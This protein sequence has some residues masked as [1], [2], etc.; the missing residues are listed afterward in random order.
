[1]SLKRY[2]YT[3]IQ[4]FELNVFSLIFRVDRLMQRIWQEVFAILRMALSIVIFFIVELLKFLAKHIFQPLVIAIFMSFGDYVIKPLLSVFFNGMVQPVSI[5]M[6]NVFSGMR[7]MFNPIGEILRRVFE[8]LA[9]LLRSVRL[10]EVTYVYS[11]R[12]TGPAR[13]IQTV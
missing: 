7:H 4:Y 6:W 8:Q 9:M 3:Q 13:R 11:D 1:M 12:D 2:R 10:F 5:F